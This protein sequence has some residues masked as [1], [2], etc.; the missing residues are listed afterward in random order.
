MYCLVRTNIPFGAINE[1]LCY[2]KVCDHQNQL[3]IGLP[4]DLAVSV[5]GST[6]SLPTSTH[7]TSTHQYIQLDSSSPLS[8]PSPTQ[9]HLQPLQLHTHPG[10]G[11]LPH[12]L[13]LAPSQVLVQYA[14]GLG[15]NKAEG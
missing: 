9:V 7:F 4:S 5:G 15:V 2:V 14:D 6:V 10:V 13:T 3:Q 1:A 8:V 12:T 11:L